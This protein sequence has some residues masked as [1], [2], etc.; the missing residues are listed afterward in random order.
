MGKIE[1]GI[2]CSIVDCKNTAMRSVSA[3]KVESSGFKVDCIRNAYLCEDHYKEFKKK[4]K[5]T[6]RVEKWRWNA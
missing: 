2:K 1:K 3:N 6:R 4:N 5:D